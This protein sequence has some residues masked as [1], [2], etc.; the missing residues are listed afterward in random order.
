MERLTF[1][2]QPRDQIH[3]NVLQP[4]VIITSTEAAAVEEEEYLGSPAAPI[5]T[6]MVDSAGARSGV[7]VSDWLPAMRIPA[8]ARR[9]YLVCLQLALGASVWGYNIGILSS[10]LV[11]QGWKS[12]LGDPRPAQKG[13][14]TGIYYAGTL[15][16]YLFLSH[17]LADAKGR[18]F[19]ARSGTFVVCLGA[20]CMASSMG[21][22]AL[23][24]MAIGRF[25][26][27]LGVG[28]ISTTVP[29]YQR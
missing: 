21:P 5:S 16:S 25:V 13:I 3:F 14:I 12:A 23:F 22:A 11:H 2:T 1:Q 20:I 27:G 10:I 17:P 19:A 28:I 26:S 29:L 6:G 7:G 8:G 4:R 24:I 18:R 9:L 15:I